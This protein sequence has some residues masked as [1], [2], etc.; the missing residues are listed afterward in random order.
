[1]LEPLKRELK[2]LLANGQPEE[3]FYRLREQVLD[4]KANCYN[5]TVLLEAS[6]NDASRKNALGTID[7]KERNISFANIR[8]ALIWLIDSILPHDLAPTFRAQHET[9]ICIPISHIYTCDRIDQNEEFQLYYYDPP[10]EL[11]EKHKGKLRFCYFY[12]DTRQGHQE[13]FK[14]LRLEIGGFLVNWQKG[15]YDP[16]VK[17]EWADIKP[18]V[19]RNPKLFRI[20]ILKEVFGHF[21]KSMHHQQPL[22]QRKLNHLAESAALKPLSKDDFVFILL[23]IDDHNWNKALVLD[24][25]QSLYKDFCNCVLDAD[26]PQFFFFFS[27]AYQKTRKD[28]QDEVKTAMNET[29]YGKS[30]PELKPVTLE[31]IS[32]WISRYP[33][34]IPPGL[35]AVQMAQKLFPDQQTMDMADVI[36]TLRRIVDQHNKGLMIQLD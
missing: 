36:I 18:Q 3:V 24:M 9:H 20:N 1:M 21:S 22:M 34:I 5:D 19:S 12:G 26:A 15:D 25:I 8:E 28:V 4:H 16:G 30:L 2:D 23:R 10:A 35:D 32:E 27:M 33:V 11:M 31:D 6:W 13:L 29:N 17:V 7:F 14:R